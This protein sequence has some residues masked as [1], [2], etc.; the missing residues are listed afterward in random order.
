MLWFPHLAGHAC[1]MH[2]PHGRRSPRTRHRLTYG[3]GSPAD[4]DDSDVIQ[5]SGFEQLCQHAHLDMQ[6]IEPFVLSWAV[7]AS[8]L[9]RL[10]RKEFGQL[11]EA[12]IDTSHKISSFVHAQMKALDAQ[13]S[14]HAF[15]TFLYGLCLE[16]GQKTMSMD[17][18][19]VASTA[20]RS[21]HKGSGS[22]R[23]PRSFGPW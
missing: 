10:T 14:F 21:T 1:N 22:H 9:G 19:D 13:P 8:A 20:C 23:R 6:G 15:Y 3:T 17:V 2:I 4:E 16:D 18:C 5:T 12:E 11:A 7:G